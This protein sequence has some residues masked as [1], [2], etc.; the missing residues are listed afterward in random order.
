VLGTDG[1]GLLPDRHVVQVGPTRSTP[2]RRV[3]AAMP[4]ATSTPTRTSFAASQAWR[5]GAPH[6][7]VRG[8]SGGGA[9]LEQ[10]VDQL[11]VLGDDQRPGL[12]LPAA[13]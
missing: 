2:G 7:T 12:Q 5:G 11:V 3:R 8:G 9:Q 1:D 13:E 6:T 10:G 4:S